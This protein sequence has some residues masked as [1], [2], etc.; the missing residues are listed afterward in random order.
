MLNT[1]TIIIALFLIVLG[2]IV[3]RAAMADDSEEY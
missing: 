1:G 2:V 3:A